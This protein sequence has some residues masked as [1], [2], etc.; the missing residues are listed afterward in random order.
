MTTATS[1]NEVPYECN[2]YPQTHPDRLAAIAKFFS[3]SPARVENCQVLEIG[4]ASGN[5]LIPMAVNL[6]NSSFLGIDLS[7]TQINTGRQFAST[8]GLKN[9]E[10]R[11]QNLADFSDKEGKY[12]YILAHGV[13]SWVPGEAR[14]R[15]LEICK[16][17]LAPGGI[18]YVSYNVLPG[19]H[20]R[21]MIRDMM[22]FHAQKFS[23][24]A[25]KIAQSRALLEFLARSI[26]DEK[27]PYGIFLKSEVELMR[28][29]NDAYLFHEHLEDTNQP[30]YFHEFAQMAQA[31]GL[32]YL[33]DSDLRTMGVA[34]MSLETRQMLATT[35]SLLD[36]EQYLDFLR[37][38]MFRMSLLVHENVEPSYQVQSRRVEEFHLASSLVPEP[39]GDLLSTS[40]LK[41]HCFGMAAVNLTEPFMKA[42]LVALHEQWPGTLSLE[43]LLS[44]ASAK[45]GLQP[46]QPGQA[47]ENLI[48]QLGGALFSYYTSLPMGAVELFTRAI[49]GAPAPSAKPRA[50]PL[51]RAQAAFTKAVTNSRHQVFHMG[52]FEHRLLTWLDG[53]R[54]TSD[55]LEQLTGLVQNQSISIHEGGLLVTDG[56]KAKEF[57]RTRL[58]LT[59]Q[60]LGKNALLA[61]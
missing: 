4:C 46:P 58:E 40:P 6:K 5:N 37:N 14:K 56:E 34:D 23:Q 11:C 53:A 29:Q 10:L 26:Q 27:N 36:T 15:L 49:P 22:R 21:G 24:S 33:G 60:L 51:A 19:W 28:D 45:I 35:G 38:R 17:N 9:L 52:D 54:N 8:L 18:A 43:E 48:Q 41:F 1:Y 20:M 39:A 16:R 57:L 44:Q 32:K 25:V 12:D 7:E 30:M 42:A 13:F 47:R 61:A 3:L 31:E 59:L 50:Y 2:P 55:I